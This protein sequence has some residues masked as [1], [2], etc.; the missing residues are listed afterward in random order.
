MQMSSDSIFTMARE[1]NWFWIS[2]YAD[3]EK[4]R[5]YPESGFVVV[6]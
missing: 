2:S 6:D 3:W 5:T 1:L 4:L